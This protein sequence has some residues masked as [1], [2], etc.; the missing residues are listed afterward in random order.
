MRGMVVS[1]R[2]VV[3]C[4]GMYSIVWTLNTVSQYDIIR[5]AARN[6]KLPTT[7]RLNGTTAHSKVVVRPSSTK[8]PSI[9]IQCSNN[10]L[11]YRGGRTHAPERGRFSCLAPGAV[12]G[13]PD[14]IPPPRTNDDDDDFQST[15][16]TGS[17]YYQ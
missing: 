13:V 12:G 11:R 9:K 16:S 4:I 2:I 14:H 5:S 7:H 17:Y 3:C 1:Y 10:V 6:F 8:P 15:D